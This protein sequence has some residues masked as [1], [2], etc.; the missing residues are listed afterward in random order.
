M[1]LEKKLICYDFDLRFPQMSAKIPPFN[2]VKGS[3]RFNGWIVCIKGIDEIVRSISFIRSMW[4]K[5]MG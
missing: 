4:T 5:K 3:F 1:G 2:N